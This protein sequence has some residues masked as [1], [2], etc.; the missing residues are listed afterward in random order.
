MTSSTRGSATRVGALV[1]VVAVGALALAPAVGAHADRDAPAASTAAAPVTAATLAA[2]RERLTACLTCMMQAAD[3]GSEPVGG[4]PAAYQDLLAVYR[5]FRALATPT[6]VDGVP[7]YGPRAMAAQHRETKRL[8]QRLQRIDDSRWPIPYRV[9]YMVVLAEM[10]GLDFAHR[11][12][13]PWRRDPAFW[14]TT[15]LGFGP[16]MHGAM[17]IPRLPLAPDKV[18]AVELQLR[19]VPAILEQAR[20]VLTEPRG[21]LARL[22]IIQKGIEVRVYGQLARDLAAHHPRL[23]PAAEGAR[24]AAQRFLDWLE[25][26][27][28]KLPAHGGIGRDEYDW[29]LRNVLLFPYTWEEMRIL[30]EREWQRSMV[31]LKLEEHRNRGIPMIEPATTLAEFERR[32]EEADAELLKW[33]RE[34]GIMTVPDWLVSPKNEGPYVLPGDRDPAKPGPFDA[35]IQRHFFR[36]TEDRDPRPLRA[37]NVPGHL[38]DGLA[39]ARDARPIRGD[40]RLFYIDGIRSE[41]WALYLEEMLTQAGF[42]ADRPKT[43]EINYILQ[44]K[45][46][47]RVLPELM[48]QANAWTY[49]EAMGS[50]TSRTP[51][52]MKPDDA[53]AQFDLELY[54]RQPG[55]GVGYYMGKVELEALMAEVALAEGRGFDVKRFHDRFF[56]SGRIPISLI[57]WELTGKDDQVRTMR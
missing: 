38:Y 36:E 4:V 18:D 5:E 39:R 45:R 16:K 46:A 27:E 7:D 2:E 25:S 56:A 57:R 10:R 31:F 23:V 17:S 50:L 19:A 29:Y 8:M 12:I 22:A 43:R 51:Y 52:W 15:N 33:L 20:R 26:I 11:V 30:G 21:D 6:V 54:L 37:H 41:G 40:A 9:D 32:R 24:D 34:A 42:L 53:I 13:R 49:R 3:G 48:M 35:P 28:A 14:S 1:G 47:A 55:Y 44:A